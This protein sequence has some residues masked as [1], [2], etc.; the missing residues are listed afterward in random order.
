MSCVNN[1]FRGVASFNTAPNSKLQSAITSTLHT[2]DWPTIL[3]I[4]ILI[5]GDSDLC[6][7]IQT[8]LSLKSNQPFNQPSIHSFLHL[9]VCLIIWSF[10]LM[11]IHFYNIAICLP[12]Y[13]F[14][15]LVLAIYLSS[16]LPSYPVVLSVFLGGGFISYQSSIHSFFHPSALPFFTFCHESLFS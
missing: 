16:F 4:S 12:V 14:D 1:D 2:K 9:A 7:S 3:H 10:Y 13:Q 11:C 6:E 15:H 8:W 5:V